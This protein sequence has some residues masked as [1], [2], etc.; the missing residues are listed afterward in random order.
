M[1]IDNIFLSSTKHYLKNKQSHFSSKEEIHQRNYAKLNEHDLLRDVQS[2]I[3]SHEVLKPYDNVNQTFNSFHSRFSS[4]IDKRPPL[5]NLSKREI[6]TRIKS[7]IESLS[8]SH[9]CS[10]SCIFQ[11]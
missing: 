9:S 1:L 2:I 11:N 10:V 4:V 6:K 3:N 5:K 7:W 8:E